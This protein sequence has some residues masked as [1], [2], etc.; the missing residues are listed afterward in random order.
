M[1][2]RIGVEIPRIVAALDEASQMY[3]HLP[4]CT[5]PSSCMSHAVQSSMLMISA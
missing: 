1:Y 5:Q 2:A 3:R 4:Q